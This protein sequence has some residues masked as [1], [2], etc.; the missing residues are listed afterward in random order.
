MPPKQFVTPP[1]LPED[2]VCR[3]LEIPNSKEWLGI[4]NSAL[5][6]LLNQYEYLQVNDTDLTIDETIAKCHEIIYAYFD[7]GVCGSGDECTLPAGLPVVRLGAGGFIEQLV[8]SAFVP[9]EGEYA[10]PPPDARTEPTAQERRC[11]AAANAENVLAQLYEM[12]SDMVAAD[13]DEQEILL[14]IAFFA[15]TI[16]F[17]AF[18]FL[19]P[20]LVLLLFAAWVAFLEIAEF[21]TADL[22]DAAFSEKLRCILYDCATDDGDV[23]TFDFN[24]VNETM[25]AGV[26][27]LA[28]TALVDLR[29][30]GQVSFLLSIIGAQ[31]LNI[32]GAT[33]E[34][35]TA[36][37]SD[38]GA[39]C[40]EFDLRETDGGFTAGTAPE[41]PSGWSALWHSGT[42]W[43][44]EAAQEVMCIEKE[45]TNGLDTY[46]THIG[47]VWT[48][49]QSAVGY[50]G[51]NL[52][53]Y[54][55]LTNE[56]HWFV[57]NPN[58]SGGIGGD[59]TPNAGIDRVTIVANLPVPGYGAFRLT[60]FYLKGTGENPFMESNCE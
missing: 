14:A 58:V 34:V 18:G 40:H 42:G 11:L 21:M 49:S 39:W 19:L 44:T 23:V 52:D 38:C 29:L 22:W 30:F 51:I 57:G 20:A 60:H 8:G 2:V 37:C 15:E 26:D 5:L 50:D 33:T 59:I 46:I 31:G 48:N 3:I 27:L 35:E 1:T 6:D 25:A 13:V 28:P 41:C 47:A 7:T 9:P 4:F 16:L 55:G 12:V 56:A 10:L 32:A 45:W 36:D 54:D 24:C 43:G 53:G 17:V